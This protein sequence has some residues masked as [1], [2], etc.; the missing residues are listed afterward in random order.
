MPLKLAL[1][2]FKDENIYGDNLF[3]FYF[4]NENGEFVGRRYNCSYYGFI[5]ELRKEQMLKR[6]PMVIIE[7]VYKRD[8][9]SKKQL[10]LYTPEERVAIV[11]ADYLD[12]DFKD[13]AGRVEIIQGG[14]VTAE[15]FTVCDANCVARK[16]WLPCFSNKYYVQFKRYPKTK[17]SAC[18]IFDYR[19]RDLNKRL[20]DFVCTD[21]DCAEDLK[22]FLSGENKEC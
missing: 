6:S 2:M 9:K 5:Q 22:K 14:I 10:K 8:R 17:L 19:Y 4:V 7:K 18:N 3:I 20:D 13:V 11:L 15:E 16:V 1:K 12:I 21:Y